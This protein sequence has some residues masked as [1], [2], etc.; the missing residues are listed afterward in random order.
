MRN[1]PG[2][3]CSATQAPKTAQPLTLKKVRSA[4][5]KDKFPTG[6]SKGQI[7]VF[8]Q[9]ALGAAPEDL[10]GVKRDGLIERLRELMD[11][12]DAAEGPAGASN[13]RARA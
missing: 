11:A 7:E 5:A 13:K 4:L 9:H 12:R 3:L 2:Q 1:Q 6:V 10:K 8:M